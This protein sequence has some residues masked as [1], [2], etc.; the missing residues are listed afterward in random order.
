MQVTILADASHC[1]H[2]KAAGYGFWVASERGKTPGGGSM[3]E[4]VASS[5]AAEMMAVCNALHA[6]IDMQLVKTGDIVL[7][8]IDCVGAIKYLSGRTVPGE[9]TD[10]KRAHKFFRELTKQHRIG[11]LF[12]H[13]KAHTGGHD[14][15]HKANNH[16]D[17]RAKDG[18]RAMRKKLK[19]LS[20]Q[21][22][23]DIN[24]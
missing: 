19:E 15:R 23:H 9:G 1:P 13:V 17:Q 6:A 12:R 7:M 18:M 14:A 4:P 10:E 5:L 24:N 2:T 8:Q 16:C 22:Q 21:K 3:R 11:V 20:M